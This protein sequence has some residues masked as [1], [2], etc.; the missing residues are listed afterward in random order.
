MTGDL[1]DIRLDRSPLVNGHLLRCRLFSDLSPPAA[2]G[3][4][5]LG[6]GS[7]IDHNASQIGNEILKYCYSSARDRSQATFEERDPPEYPPW[8]VCTMFAEIGPKEL[9]F[10]STPRK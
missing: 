3:E 7:L 2:T 8:L 5:V 4:Y 6:G 1:E 9:T 10:C